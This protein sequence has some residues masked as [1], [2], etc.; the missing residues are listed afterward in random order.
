MPRVDSLAPILAQARTGSPGTAIALG[1]GVILVLALLGAAIALIVR[2][3]MSA[4]DVGPA[5]AGFTLSDLRRLH[6]EGDLSDDEY[7][8]AKAKIVDGYQRANAPAADP[9]DPIADSLPVE[10]K[11]EPERD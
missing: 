5:S 9:N 3:R 1:L 7:Q 6:R 2:K 8:R 10:V 4:G 11:P